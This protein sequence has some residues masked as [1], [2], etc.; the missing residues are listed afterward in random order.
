MEEK[1]IVLKCD[2]YDKSFIYEKLNE[3]IKLLNLKNIPNRILIKPNMLSAR[4]PEQGVTTHPLI[5]SAIVEIFKDKKIIIGDSPAN[6]SK[7]I[8]EYWI[9]CGYKEISEKYKIELKKFDTSIPIDIYINNKLYKIPITSL[10]NDYYI[11]NVPKFKTHNLTTLTIGIKN[12]YGLIPNITKTILHSKF[13]NSYD[14]SFFLVEFYKKIEDKI[15]LTVVDG[16]IAME[17]DGPSSGKLKNLGY[18]IIGEK[19]IYVDYVCCKLIGVE[20]EKVDFIKIYKEKY[21]IDKFEVIGE[22]Q[23]IKNFKL[24]STKK[25][26]LIKNSFFTKL[27]S[28]ISKFFK[29]IPVI[30]KEICRKCYACYNICP[31]KA[32]S[33]DLK[34]DRK[35]CILC[36]CCFE[37]CSYKAIKLKKSLITRIFT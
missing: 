20:P 15:F 27:L 17:G 22:F 3:G 28:P 37:V 4:K 18:I 19:P 31:V 14:F 29:I 24:P 36:L 33:K 13:I 25:Y 26:F 32:I 2:R 21:G 12:L 11:L 34:F 30:K 1:I 35:K 16:I 8:E 6:I 7:P 10:L 5:L 23:Q 9:K